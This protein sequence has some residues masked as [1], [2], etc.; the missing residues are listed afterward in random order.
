MSNTIVQD[1]QRGWVIWDLCNTAA[2]DATSAFVTTGEGTD[3]SKAAQGTD[4]NVALAYFPDNRTIQVD[5]TILAGSSNVRLR[6]YDPVA[7]T[8]STIAATEAQ[9]TARAVTMPA[10]RGDGT[11][12]FVLVVDSSD[13]VA[14]INTT[15]QNDVAD[16]NG[17]NLVPRVGTIA[18][19]QAGDAGDLN[20]TVAGPPR[21]G[22]IAVTQAD[23]IADLNGNHSGPGNF[24]G[25][26]NVTQQS[27]IGDL[28]GTSATGVPPIRVGTNT[29]TK[30]Y[31]GA[32]Q[33]TRVYLGSTQL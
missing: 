33:V 2:W 13:R 3:S 31:A 7:G 17:T 1:F 25:T 26:I 8:F 12:D 9:Q 21:V 16:L 20:G 27:N 4:G 30:I 10:A 24:V 5:T 28:N 18:V 19:T 14:T 23:N 22:T 11:R 15:Q 6:W 29:V 32:T